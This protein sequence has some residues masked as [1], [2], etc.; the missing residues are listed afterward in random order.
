MTLDKVRNDMID[1]FRKVNE[2]GV[3]GV[4]YVSATLVKSEDDDRGNVLY[5][6]FF[7]GE[8]RVSAGYKLLDKDEP[9]VEMVNHEE[10]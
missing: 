4:D 7:Q 5:V 2:E 6:T 10:V 9:F 1:Y 8:E 3:D